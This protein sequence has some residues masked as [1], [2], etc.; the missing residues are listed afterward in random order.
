MI[1]TSGDCASG[2]NVRL[3]FS[4]RVGDKPCM[5]LSARS[6]TALL[7]PCLGGF[8]GRTRKR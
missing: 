4:A 6:I 2:H 3:Y 8:G 7:M 1:Q 5:S